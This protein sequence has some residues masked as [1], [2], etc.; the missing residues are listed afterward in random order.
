[1]KLNIIGHVDIFTDTSVAVSAMINSYARIFMHKVKLS[2]LSLGGKI[3]YSNTDSI[4]TNLDL[5]RLLP[6]LIGNKLG[7]LKPEYEINKGYF[8]S[9]KT[10]YL[11]TKDNIEIIKSKG[12][13][14]NSLTLEDFELMYLKSQ[15]VKGNK[16]YT[17]KD[18]SKGSVSIFNDSEVNVN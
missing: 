15:S 18:L 6:D 5:E 7:L 13:N 11:N 1:M 8:I 3:F 14:S 2:I 17:K 12:V 16:V 10:Y 9:N 4:V